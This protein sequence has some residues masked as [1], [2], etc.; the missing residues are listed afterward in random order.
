MIENFFE[1]NGFMKRFYDES[2][3]IFELQNVAANAYA[4]NC[5]T[6]MRVF[7]MKIISDWQ[8]LNFGVCWN[9]LIGRNSNFWKEKIDILFWESEDLAARR[10]FLCVRR[11][12]W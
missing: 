6:T 3:S 11:G 1:W 9:G 8:T 2:V 5:S 12:Q 4:D 10:R 7:L